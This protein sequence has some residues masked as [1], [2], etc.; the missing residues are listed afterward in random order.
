MMGPA[1]TI[2]C[3][4]DINCLDNYPVMTQQD[5]WEFGTMGDAPYFDME[6]GNRILR[7][8]DSDSYEGR[9]IGDFQLYNEAP[10]KSAIA[11]LKGS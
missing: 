8:T 6:D 3:F 5:T 11:L 10:G 1:G 9:I 4:M 7:E 2:K